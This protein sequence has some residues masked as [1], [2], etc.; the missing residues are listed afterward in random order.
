M[1]KVLVETRFH[2]VPNRSRW[3][4][5]GAVVAFPVVPV[6]FF[7]GSGYPGDPWKISDIQK[8]RN[9]N[10]LN[11][12]N[13]SPDLIK[14]HRWNI[15]ISSIYIMDIQWYSMCVTSMK[16][17]TWCFSG[18]HAMGGLRET[19]RGMMV[20]SSR[21]W[22]DKAMT[23]GPWQ[24]KTNKIEERNNIFDRSTKS[25]LIFWPFKSKF[26]SFLAKRNGCA[27]PRIWLQ[28]LAAKNEWDEQTAEQI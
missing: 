12:C 1:W 26:R 13:F 22:F 23:I 16:F 24:H 19:F 9:P 2:R 6:L 28:V 5:A 3:P 20:A 7:P 11:I 4:G 10:R 27:F 8:S 25:Q 21:P 18:W 15:R 14:F 17:T